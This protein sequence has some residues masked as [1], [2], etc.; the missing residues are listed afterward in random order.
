MS[1]LPGMERGGA[2]ADEA[3][4]AA[5]P[6]CGSGSITTTGHEAGEDDE[7]PEAGP[8]PRWLCMHCLFR[9]PE[10]PLSLGL[11]GTPE[12]EQQYLDEKTAEYASLCAEAELPPDPE[13]PTI[14]SYWRRS[15]GRRVFLMSFLWGRVRV[16][17]GLELV[18]LGGPP[19]YEATTGTVPDGIEC[20]RAERLARLAALRLD[21]KPQA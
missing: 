9:W 3:I 14:G 6:D 10:K 21:R 19:V 16:E 15:N 1:M 17:R 12:A 20:Q 8:V 11:K 13:E 2:A 18:P 4:P 5:C 7:T